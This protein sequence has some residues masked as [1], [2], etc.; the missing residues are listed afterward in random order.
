MVL[1][2]L[3]VVSGR[4]IVLSRQTDGYLVTQRG[5]ESCLLAC[6]LAYMLAYLLTFLPT[7]VVVNLIETT[8]TDRNGEKLGLGGEGGTWMP[9]W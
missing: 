1:I 2:S 9:D 5:K 7:Y 8:E 3:R 6:L 4:Y